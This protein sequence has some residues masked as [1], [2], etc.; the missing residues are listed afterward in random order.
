MNKKLNKKKLFANFYNPVFRITQ[1]IKIKLFNTVNNNNIFYS[2]L[3]ILK[4][5]SL[6]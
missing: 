5:L 4:K 6:F 3:V 2:K 1:L